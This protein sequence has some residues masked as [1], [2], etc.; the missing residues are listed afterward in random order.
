M[1]HCAILLQVVM[2]V[3]LIQS[4]SNNNNDTYILYMFPLMPPALGLA[5]RPCSGPWQLKLGDY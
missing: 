1:N 2:V 5:C 3:L 4:I